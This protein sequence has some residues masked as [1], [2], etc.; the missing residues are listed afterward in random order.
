MLETINWVLKLFLNEGHQIGV[1][2]PNERHGIWDVVLQNF[3]KNQ[4]KSYCR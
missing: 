2:T 1:M 3:V 4:R